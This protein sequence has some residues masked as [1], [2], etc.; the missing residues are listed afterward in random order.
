MILHP[1]KILVVRGGALGDFILTLPVLA[2]LRRRFPTHVLEIL[3]YE[4]AASLAVAGGLA[5]RVSAL[6]S[7]A[8]AGFFARDGAWPA[9][10]AEYFA[11]FE[12]I[13]SYVYDPETIFQSNVSRC[14]AARFLA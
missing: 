5:E 8:L 7:P 1:K 9:G 14:G 4:R 13:V 10:A 11:G 3:G 6:E 12:L 2:A